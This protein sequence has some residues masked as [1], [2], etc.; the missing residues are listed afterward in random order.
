MFYVRTVFQE[1][2]PVKKAACAIL[3]VICV[4]IACGCVKQEE[5]YVLKIGSENVYTPEFRFYF[6]LS[7]ITFEREGGADIWMTTINGVKAEEAAKERAFESIARIKV[8]CA[9]AAGLGIELDD[10]DKAAAAELAEYYPTALGWE[11]QEIALTQE[12][13]TEIIDETLIYSKVFDDVTKN[14]E[15]SEK[16]FSAF[17]ESYVTDPA[18][19]VTDEEPA[20]LYEALRLQYTQKV[21]NDFF[22]EQY[23][24]WEAGVQIDRNRE[25]WDSIHILKR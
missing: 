20:A 1:V 18:N 2:P 22:G 14:V 24:K 17:Y 3:F 21:K 11:L 12:Q 25:Q 9:Q 4:I 10:E 7:Q 19:G 15:I 6:L 5:P 8:T 23:S 13:L 16:D